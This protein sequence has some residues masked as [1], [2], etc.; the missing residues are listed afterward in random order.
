MCKTHHYAICLKFAYAVSLFY[1]NKTREKKENSCPT[2]CS[3]FCSETCG[4]V[5]RRW[6]PA[7][8]MHVIACTYTCMCVCI[9]MPVPA[10]YPHG[11]VL[12][13]LDLDKKISQP[14]WLVKN[15]NRV[16]LL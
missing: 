7:F 3:K 11:P 14:A 10:V 4:E 15:R 6:E 2:L 5:A 9:V 8:G 12:V 16:E 1:M 13:H